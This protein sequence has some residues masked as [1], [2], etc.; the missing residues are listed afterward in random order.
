MKKIN[1]YAYIIVMSIICLTLVGCFKQQ[2]KNE[3]KIINGE[4]YVN[5]EV[6]V[7]TK[8]NE[9]EDPEDLMSYLIEA[10]LN[11]K[12]DDLEETVKEIL[13]FY[14]NEHIGDKYR[15]FINVRSKS[16]RVAN[17]SNKPTTEQVGEYGQPTICWK[18]GVFAGCSKEEIWEP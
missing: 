6:S 4:L 12:A 9:S 5:G 17:W 11:V 2:D 13:A 15:I 14:I 7:F 8:G 3:V 16:R 1:M 18:V 10:N